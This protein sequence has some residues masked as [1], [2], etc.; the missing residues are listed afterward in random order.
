M[1]GT[2]LLPTIKK[3]P[4][5]RVVF[6]VSM[7]VIAMYLNTLFTS[8]S[9]LLS[10]IES[11]GYTGLFLA[12]I[13]SGFNLL[14]PIP[15]ITFF[16]TL[17]AAGFI[18]VLTVLVISFGMSL[19]DLFGYLLG[20]SA[21]GTETSKKWEQRVLRLKQKHPALLPLFVFVYAA[22]VPLPNELIVVP[23]AAV[24]TRMVTILVPIF[25]GNIIFN[26]I[27]AFGLMGIV[28]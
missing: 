13:L 14:V 26:A 24:G 8:E 27:I 22:V 6:F 10:H 25:I 7:I 5:I 20:M 11:F 17:V 23:L 15:I 21:Q 4:W 2:K 1:F 19:G 12:S 3:Y 28:G 18:P 9:E 16:P